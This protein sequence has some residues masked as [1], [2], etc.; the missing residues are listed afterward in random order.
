MRDLKKITAAMLITTMTASLVACG[1]S[2]D[3]K[4]TTSEK[5][6]EVAKAMTKA[7][8]TATGEGY[9]QKDETVYVITDAEGNVNSAK[10]V[11]WL[12]N[13]ENVKDLKDI[14]ALTDII[15]VKGDEEFKVNGDEIVFETSGKDIYYEGNLSEGNLPFE[16]KITYELDGAE[17]SAADLAGQ[18][19]HVKMH[20]KFTGV[21]K[22]KVSVDGKDKEVYVPFVAVTGAML[23]TNIFSNVQIDNGKVISNGQYQVAC[24]F[25]TAGLVEN[26]DTE[27]LNASIDG[28]TLEAD[29]E[30]FEP[31]YMM[32]FVTNSVL[33]NV[34]VSEA[35]SLKDV[36]ANVTKLTDASNLLLQGTN[37]LAEK[38]PELVKGATTL[39]DGVKT[40]YGYTGDLL[41]GASTIN[42]NMSVL[43]TSLNKIS[44]GA[45]SL[46]E[47]MGLYK[48]GVG[49]LK[50]GTS[51]VYQG[52]LL[53]Q[54]KLNAVQT[55]LTK[56]IQTYSKIVSDNKAT[57]EALNNG[58]K[59]YTQAGSTYPMDYQTLAK[60]EGYY[61]AVGALE[62]LK[63]VA[64][65]FTTKDPATGMTM[66]ESI[67][68]LVNGG[69]QV[70]A[71][72]AELYSKAEQL[73]NEGTSVLANGASQA[74]NGSV[75]LSEGTNTYV[76][77]FTEYKAGM[78]ELKD[79][80][81]ELVAGVKLLQSGVNELN[82]GMK[83]FVDEGINKITAVVG[84]GTEDE[85]ATVKAVIMAAQQ[86]DS[87]SGTA[88]GQASDV[89]FVIKSN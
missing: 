80:T 5:D 20:V 73:I 4:E 26:F 86:Y 16:M 51:Q 9:A 6:K 12:K 74:Y 22:T 59:Q 46:N 38:L 61:Q 85:L 37:T 60:V 52:L 41:D 34:D 21:K 36:F 75:L 72:A 76:S 88:D 13:I 40:L 82:E 67:T 83:K 23:D 77:K 66:S 70:D 69:K 24:G 27:K 35:D 44:V 7:E 64:A 87:V 57:I 68:A 39:N 15:N 31:A 79:K 17:I 29:V 71:G 54:K 89:K 1:N 65:K 56:N 11:E 10:A 49:T 55:E 18:S 62:A 78:K 45:A 50:D 3:T 43:S 53:A 32:T 81:P 19:G 48:D 63:T 84:E 25:G 42:T 47:K 30:K 8:N 33:D 2:N 14:T 58:V 28:F